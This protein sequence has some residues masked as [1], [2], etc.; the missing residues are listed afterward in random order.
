MCGGDDG[1]ALHHSH[2]EGRRGGGGGGRWGREER[3]RGKERKGERRGEEGGEGGR[4]GRGKREGKEGVSS[5]AC[6]TYQF[7]C[8]CIWWEGGK[9]CMRVGGVHLMSSTFSFVD[10]C[11]L[12]KP[13]SFC[14]ETTGVVAHA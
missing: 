5:T 9:W 12:V 8:K 2:L 4:R 14:R 7:S 6:I 1:L 10:R 3:E 11:I 13:L